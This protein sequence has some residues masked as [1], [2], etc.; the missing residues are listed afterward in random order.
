M[1]AAALKCSGGLVVAAAV[2][3][4]ATVSAA[5][6][7]AATAQPAQDDGGTV[8]EGLGF[9]VPWSALPKPP[10]GDGAVSSPVTL[11][12][13]RVVTVGRKGPF[14]RVISARLWVVRS[15]NAL[16]STGQEGACEVTRSPEPNSCFRIRVR[17]E[18]AGATTADVADKGRL[19]WCLFLNNST[20]NIGSLRGHFCIW[21]DRDVGPAADPARF[22]RA[23]PVWVLEG[24]SWARQD[25]VYEGAAGS[26]ANGLTQ[27]IVGI[28]AGVQPCVRARLTRLAWKIVTDA[29]AVNPAR[30][31]RI[32]AAI[33]EDAQTGDIVGR[34]GSLVLAP[35]LDEPITHVG[36]VE[37]SGG[38][39][40]IHHSTAPGGYERISVERFVDG[41]L[42]LESLHLWRLALTPNERK[43]VAAN[44]AAAAPKVK[45]FN[46][47]THVEG[48]VELASTACDLANRR[49]CISFVQ[50]VLE[51]VVA[52]TAVRRT[53]PRLKALVDEIFGKRI[54]LGELTVEDAVMMAIVGK[55]VMDKDK[56]SGVGQL[57]PYVWVREEILAEVRRQLQAF[58]QDLSDYVSPWC[59]VQGLERG[60][61]PS[62][63]RGLGTTGAPFTYGTLSGVRRPV[64]RPPA[65]PFLERVELPR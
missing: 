10:P 3:L 43:R 4:A 38:R 12:T 28:S 19:R 24:E 32:V 54:G 46:F 1:W 25:W 65:P 35:F 63:V 62:Y 47:V 26:P 60:L 18:L 21:P 15:A 45:G 34:T 36:V 37:R 16:R 5:P 11:P 13:P 52:A 42:T 48:G 8:R 39:V 59:F 64:D 40:W 44:I 29:P 6:V 55:V 50:E 56:V 22:E 30:R 14:F 57:V 31:Q 33:T 58:K 51:P 27:V 7:G 53:D 23:R 41:A 17:I 9:S 2:A 49:S 61:D 20:G